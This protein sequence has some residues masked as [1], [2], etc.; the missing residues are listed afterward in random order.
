MDRETLT[1]SGSGSSKDGSTVFAE[2]V[3]EGG[4]DE[5]VEDLSVV[6][7]SQTRVSNRF[8][9]ISLSDGFS[10]VHFTETQVTRISPSSPLSTVIEPRSPRVTTVEISHT[11]LVWDPFPKVGLPVD[12]I[13]IR[14]PSLSATGGDSP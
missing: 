6:A 3:L 2:P 12:V 10:L 4:K 11:S 7:G 14:T 8:E 5:V 1:S 13:S 9:P